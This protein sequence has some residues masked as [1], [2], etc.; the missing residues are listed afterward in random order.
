MPKVIRPMLDD[1]AGVGPKEPSRFPF[2][3]S[4]PLDGF[5]GGTGGTGGTPEDLVKAGGTAGWD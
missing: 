4:F 1:A 3:S 5:F 2:P